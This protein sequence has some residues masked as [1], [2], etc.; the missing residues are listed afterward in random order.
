M[1][2]QSIQ[3]IA[4][5]LG[6]GFLRQYA[7]IE[8]FEPAQDLVWKLLMSVVFVYMATRVP[9]MLGNAGTFDSLGQHTLLRPQPAGD[10]DEVRQDSRAALRGNGRRACR[11]SSGGGGCHGGGD[12]RGCGLGPEIGWR[13]QQPPVEMQP[14]PDLPRGA[15]ASDLTQ[16]LRVSTFTHE[17]GKQ[18]DGGHAMCN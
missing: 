5:A 14:G 6:F 18:G 2:Q 1:F 16:Y 17:P 7:A 8:A 4:L 13:K 15:A 9:S 12:R 10:I 11:S 3:L